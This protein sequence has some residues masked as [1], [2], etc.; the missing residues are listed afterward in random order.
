MAVHIRR[1]KFYCESWQA[2]LPDMEAIVRGENAYYEVERIV[3]YHPHPTNP[4]EHYMLVKWY[5]FDEIDNEWVSCHSLSRDIPE[6]MLKALA[7]F[8][9][10]TNRTFLFEL[11]QWLHGTPRWVK[12]FDDIFVHML[13]PDRHLPA[14]AATTRAGVA[15]SV[16]FPRP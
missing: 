10:I 13:A 14:H 16:G 9:E 3:D 2:N 12:L 8:K 1:I 7:R 5:G 4:R 11:R 6:M 15:S